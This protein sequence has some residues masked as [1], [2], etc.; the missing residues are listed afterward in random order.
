MSKRSNLLAATTQ[1]KQK[2]TKETKIQSSFLWFPSVRNDQG[3]CINNTATMLPRN[4]SA[5]IAA[6][7][8]ITS[9]SRSRDVDFCRNGDALLKPVRAALDSAGLVSVLRISFDIE[10]FLFLLV[11]L[12]SSR[13][14]RR[15]T[16]LSG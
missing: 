10:I 2:I 4:V 12:C 11:L 8:K 6:T 9:W 15:L 16:H 5:P 14:E 7:P 1:T 13:R 3:A